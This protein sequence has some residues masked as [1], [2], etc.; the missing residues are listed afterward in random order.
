MFVGMASGAALGSL[1]LAQWGWP[2]VVA[3]A[4]GG[5]LAALAARSIGRR[6]GD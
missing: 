5:A 6:E 3:V 1:A 4:T 2:G